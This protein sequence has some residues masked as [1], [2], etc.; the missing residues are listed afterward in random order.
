M[1]RRMES[2]A[3]FLLKSE[4]LRLSANSVADLQASRNSDFHC[5]VVHIDF[6]VEFI[7]V[8][9]CEL[10]SMIATIESNQI[11]RTNW[12]CARLF[13]SFSFFN[14]NCNA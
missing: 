5:P 12:L 14:A 2:F 10:R 1:D 13:I 9:S 11:F 4:F 8:Y 6:I 3:N 7:Q